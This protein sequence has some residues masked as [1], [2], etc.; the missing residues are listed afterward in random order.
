MTHDLDLAVPR[1][2]AASPVLGDAAANAGA[3][4]LYAALARAAS[5]KPEQPAVVS[6]RFAPL[7][8]RRLHQLIDE[9]RLQLRQAGFGRDARIGIMLPEAPQAAVAIVAIACAAVAVPIDPRLGPAELDQFL[10]QLPLDALLIGS[11]S[12]QGQRAAERHGLA[13]IKAEPAEDGTPALLLDMPGAAQPA[14]DELPLPDAPAFILRSSGTTALPKLIP[15]S[16]RNMLTAARK[17]QRWFGLDGGDRCL[18]VS[19]PYYSH[20]LKVTILTPLLAG[21]SVAF[22]LSP[23]V[24]DLHEWFDALRPTWYSAG[25]ALHRAVLEAATTYP[26]GLGAHRPRFASS[27]G[28]PLGQDIIDAFEQAMGFPLLEHYGS[29]EAA[30]IAVNTPRS[31]RMAA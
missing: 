5:M 27:G 11:D 7:D 25:P 30:Q 1:S 10:Q 8:Y 4:T 17:W 3:T 31:A 19:A 15:F 14:A 21:G 9:T 18:C 6:T 13:L 20:G 24:V 23:A 12:E 2:G 16:H 29:S 26:E 28:A 22:P